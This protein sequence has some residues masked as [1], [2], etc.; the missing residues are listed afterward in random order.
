MEQ[1]VFFLYNANSGMLNGAIDSL[2]KFL[3]PSTYPCSLCELTHGYFGEKEIWRAF[4][5]RLSEKGYKLRGLH[6]DELGEWPVTFTQLPAVYL[7]FSG[8]LTLLL[9]PQELRKMTSTRDLI[10]ILDL[11]LLNFSTLA[12]NSR[13]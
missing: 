12:G 2:H 1:T 3:S 5:G 9:S 4:S 8:S 10:E 7:Y 13:A 11:K 6:K